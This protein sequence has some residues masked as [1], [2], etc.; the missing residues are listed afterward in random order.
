MKL[1]NWNIEVYRDLD[2]G[3]KVFQVP[4]LKYISTSQDLERQN[5]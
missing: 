3:W 1:S 4:E 2:L 5:P